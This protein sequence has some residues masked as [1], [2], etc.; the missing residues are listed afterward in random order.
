M[1]ME[2]KTKKII[3]FMMTALLSVMVLTACSSSDSPHPRRLQR[4]NM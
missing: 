2:K 1:T 4:M 3:A